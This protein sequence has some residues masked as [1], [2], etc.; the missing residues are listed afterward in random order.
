MT[1]TQ[2]VF[3]SMLQDIAELKKKVAIQQESRDIENLESHL[4]ERIATLFE[5]AM[6]ATAVQSE[7]LQSLYTQVQELVG[8][9]TE[10][11]KRTKREIIE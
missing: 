11:R 8:E 10:D 3:D 5:N 7:T 1:D 2:G 9:V 4:S 6:E